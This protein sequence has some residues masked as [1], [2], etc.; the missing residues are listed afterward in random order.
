MERVLITGISGFI[1]NSLCDFIKRS[2]LSCYICGVDITPGRTSTKN[3]F[4]GDMNDTRFLKDAIAK[5]RPQYIFHMAGSTD[6]GEDFASLVSKNVFLTKVLLDVAMDLKNLKTRIIIPGSAAE[7]GRVARK[8]LPVKEDCPLEPVNL[9]GLSKM[10]QSLLAM[11]YCRKGLDVVIGRIFNI[12]GRGTPCTFSIGKFAH[13]IS[14]IKSG[15]KKAIIEAGDLDAERDFLDIDD[16]CS[17]L[18]AIAANGRKGDVYNICYGK[19]YKIKGM[20]NR[21]LALAETKGVKIKR[22]RARTSEVKH[23]KGCNRK[24]RRDTGWHPSVSI[25]ES[26][27][28]TFYYYNN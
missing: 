17:A 11:S 13:D 12:I 1:G 3:N 16:V 2:F 10:C 7:Y 4:V 6:R 22:L 21:L 14:L 15:R 9:Y 18:V 26:L 27:K 8:D 25:V 20:L 23:I 28:N 5:A 24:I 19:A